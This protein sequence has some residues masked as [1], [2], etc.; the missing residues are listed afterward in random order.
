MNSIL[1]LPLPTRCETISRLVNE[2]T[3]KE[4]ENFFPLLIE[5]LFGISNQVGW[6]LRQIKFSYNPHEYELLVKFLHPNGPVFKL[7]YKLLSDCHLKYDFP[8]TYLPV[9]KNI[10]IFFNL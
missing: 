6:K 5:D 2:C 1:N 8:L 10:F 9:S 7:C 3:N 4:L